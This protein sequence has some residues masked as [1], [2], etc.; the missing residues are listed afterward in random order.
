MMNLKVEIKPIMELVPSAIESLLKEIFKGVKLSE[1]EA[2][3]VRLIL[4][5]AIANAISHG[6]NYDTGLKVLVAINLDGNVLKMSVKDEGKGFNPRAVP[7]PVSGEEPYKSS[8][9]GIYLIRKNAD[10]VAFNASGNEI[11]ITKKI[12]KDG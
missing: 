3:Q 12:G 9:R 10:S 11:I 2:F 7:D 4:E 5:E 6:I 1:E 8:G